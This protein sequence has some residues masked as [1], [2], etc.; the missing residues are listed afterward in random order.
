[1]NKLFEVR[2]RG[3][4]MTVLATSLMPERSDKTGNETV[5][6]MDAGYDIKMLLAERAILLTTLCGGDTKTQ[7]QADEWRLNGTRTLWA[8]HR[9]IIEN[10]NDLTSTDLIDVEFILGETGTKKE[11]E[12]FYKR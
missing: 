5:M 1:M 10:W 3:T 2:D 6:L 11:S 8:A 12:V 9:Y 4:R 7:W